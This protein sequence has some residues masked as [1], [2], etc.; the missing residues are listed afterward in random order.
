MLGG[1]FAAAVLAKG[2]VTTQTA[3]GTLTKT[4]LPPTDQA[5]IPGRSERQR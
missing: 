1:P 2:I 4:T 3:N 5:N